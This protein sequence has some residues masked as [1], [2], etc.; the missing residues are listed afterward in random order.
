MGSAALADLRLVALVS[1]DDEAATNKCTTPLKMAAKK[2]STNLLGTQ[3]S[4]QG[5]LDSDFF[6][7]LNSRLRLFLNNVKNVNSAKIITTLTSENQ[8]H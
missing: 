1:R 6:E 4:W 2:A 8:E 7:I 5:R 3:V